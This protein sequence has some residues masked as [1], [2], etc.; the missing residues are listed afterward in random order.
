M[1]KLEYFK[2]NVNKIFTCLNQLDT[3]LEDSENSNLIAGLNEYKDILIGF[4]ELLSQDT[5]TV[6]EEGVSQ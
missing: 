4:S 3:Y 5:P 6:S 1:D 2:E